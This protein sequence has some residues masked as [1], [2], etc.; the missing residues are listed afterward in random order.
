MGATGGATGEVEWG[1]KSARQMSDNP[2]DRFRLAD[3][4]SGTP[5]ASHLTRQRW[6]G[7]YLS[8][9]F[10]VD[11][12]LVCRMLHVPDEACGF[13]SRSFAGFA[14]I[15]ALGRAH[16]YPLRDHCWRAPGL[17]QQSAH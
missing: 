16:E 6:D 3:H 14:Q 8:P 11:K 17:E 7:F 13:W 4:P 12:D 15:A 2:D 10:H 9:S 1:Q 5:V